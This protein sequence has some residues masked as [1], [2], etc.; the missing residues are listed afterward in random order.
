MTKQ[1]FEEGKSFTMINVN[2]GTSTYKYD[3]GA[4]IEQFR[5]ATGQLV[6]ELHLLNIETI[7]RVMVSCYTF[8]LGSKITK[9]LRFEDMLEYAESTEGTEGTIFYNKDK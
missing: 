4:V 8:I 5:S 7:G 6:M 1:G 9:R 3:R 2:G